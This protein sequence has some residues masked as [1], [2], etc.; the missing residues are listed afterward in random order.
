MSIETS[1]SPLEL[2]GQMRAA[3][4]AATTT[5]Q[6]QVGLESLVKRHASYCWLATVDDIEMIKIE[7]PGA[8]PRS[9]YR[10]TA[11]YPSQDG[12]VLFSIDYDSCG[13]QVDDERIYSINKGDELLITGRIRQ[14]SLKADECLFEILASKIERP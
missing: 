5:L 6:K 9:T 7:E 13:N 10:V 1:P 3:Y 8:M 2:V 12:V 11:H 14:F 4:K